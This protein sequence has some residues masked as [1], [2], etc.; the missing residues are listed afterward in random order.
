MV[1]SLRLEAADL[2]NGVKVPALPSPTITVSGAVYREAAAAIGV[3]NAFVHVGD[4]GIG[5]LRVTNSAAAD[6]FSENL[7]AT[8]VSLTGRE[9][10][11]SLSKSP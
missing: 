5:A 11:L 3:S 6:G 8:L 1:R 4:S 2:G 10:D 9:N 7:V